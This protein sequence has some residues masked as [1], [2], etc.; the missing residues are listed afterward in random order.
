MNTRVLA[1]AVVAPI[2]VAL[3]AGCTGGPVAADPSPKPSPSPSP[4]STA[5]VPP[6]SEPESVFDIDCADVAVAMNDFVGFGADGVKE[7][8]SLASAPNWYPGPAEFMMK[9][10]GGMVCAYD[11]EQRADGMQDA[12][13]VVIVPDAQRMIN[14]LVSNGYAEQPSECLEGSCTLM[15]RA[16]D[17]LLVGSVHSAQI[18]SDATEGARALAQTWAENASAGQQEEPFE[19]VASEVAGADCEQLMASAR[20]GELWGVTTHLTDEFGGWGV[21]AEVYLVVDG[22]VICIYGDGGEYDGV[23]HLQLTDLPGG[24]WA[25]DLIEGRTPITVTGADKAYSG[26]GGTS[27]YPAPFIDILVGADWIRLTGT[28]SSG[29]LEPVAEAV[30]ANAAEIEA[31]PAPR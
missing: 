31:M 15:A 12:W 26:M 28:G 9:R 30:A 19:V 4:S 13:E 11:G 8:M 22:A 20:L 1:A 2:L 5:E 17:A 18:A 14:S 27:T 3:L 7:R 6:V 16:G 29:D 21:P 24:A 25:F 23:Q 10:A